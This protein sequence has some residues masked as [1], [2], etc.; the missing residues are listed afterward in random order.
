MSLNSSQSSFSAHGSIQGT[1]LNRR[2]ASGISMTERYYYNSNR[3]RKIEKRGEYPTRCATTYQA[4]KL[5]LNTEWHRFLV[6]A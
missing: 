6:I 3:L 5:R 1:Q 4:V 2:G